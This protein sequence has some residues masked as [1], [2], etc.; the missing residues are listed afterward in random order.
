M[1]IGIIIP[2]LNEERTLPRTL[3]HLRHECFDDLVIVDGGSRDQTREVAARICQ[4]LGSLKTRILSTAPGR[5]HQMNV[6]AAALDSDILVFLH[7]DTLLPRNSRMLIEQAMHHHSCVGGRFDVQF[8]MDRGYAWLI[9][10]MMNLRSRLTGMATGDQAIFVKK[11]VFHQIGGFSEIPIMEDIDLSRKLKR[12]GPT[13]A[14][15]A[16]V[17]TS[18]RRWEHH[19]PLRTIL[20]MWALRS[21]YWVG[22]SPH[23]LHKFYGVVR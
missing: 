18:F 3:D 19:G 7:A 13:A 15:R 23:T 4:T 5:G 6:G 20:L 2:T 22:L 9:S 12:H 21:L 17:T 16:K 1:T 10:R 14:L 8:E 11:S